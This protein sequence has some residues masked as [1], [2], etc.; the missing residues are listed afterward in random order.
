MAIEPD[1]VFSAAGK[2]LD[3]AK[4]KTLKTLTAAVYALQALSF[5]F[6]IS[7]LVAAVINYVKRQAVRGTRFE[8]HFR[9]QIRTFWFTLLWSFL[10]A[11]TFAV[12][13]GYVILIADMIWFIYRIVKGWLA[14]AEG[15][16]MY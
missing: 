1:A 8:S 7:L 14:L 5:F 6:G 12:A 2:R 9:W 16:E 10:G 15:K 11:L 4:D 3:P 13:I